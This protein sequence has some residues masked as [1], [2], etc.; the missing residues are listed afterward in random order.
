VLIAKMVFFFGENFVYVL[1]FAKDSGRYLFLVDNYHCDVLFISVL[2]IKMIDI[3]Y[4]PNF[5]AFFMGE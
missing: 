2:I 4:R 5:V 3:F 1:L